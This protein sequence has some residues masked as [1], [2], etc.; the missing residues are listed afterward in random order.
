MATL[1]YLPETK[2][3]DA[4]NYPEGDDLSVPVVAKLGENGGILG[5]LPNGRSAFINIGIGDCGT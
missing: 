1:F 3:L 4:R 2:L 5:F